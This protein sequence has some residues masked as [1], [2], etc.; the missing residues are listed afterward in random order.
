[1]KTSREQEPPFKIDLPNPWNPETQKKLL[2]FDMDET[3]IH[4][5]EDVEKE[6]TDVILDIDF[7]DGDIV[8]AGINV[9]PY[10]YECI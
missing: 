10:I 6:E 5:V 1:M 4:C 9:R 3:L 2:I 7:G 8:Y